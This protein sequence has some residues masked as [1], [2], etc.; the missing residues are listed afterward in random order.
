[1]TRLLETLLTLLDALAHPEDFNHQ[2][3][4]FADLEEEAP[5]VQA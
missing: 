2:P 5:E 4:T 3:D 1:M